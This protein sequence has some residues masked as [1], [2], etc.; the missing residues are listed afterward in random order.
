MTEQGAAKLAPKI[1]VRQ[2][3]R[4]SALRLV[5]SVV[6]DP[7]RAMRSVYD[8]YGPLVEFGF[9]I[10]FYKR[11]QRF[12]LAVGARYNERVL[13]DTAT[14]GAGGLM[15]PGPKGST[16]RRIRSGLVSI[17]G[18]QHQYYRRLFLPPVRRAAVDGM[19]GQIGEIVQRAT[20]DWRR[21]EVVDLWPLVREVA[22]KVA[23]SVLFG[24]KE[25]FDFAEALTVADLIHH[26]VRMASSPEVRGCPINLR[27]LPYWRML[28]HAEQ[29]DSA[30]TSWAKKRRGQSRSNDLLSLFVNSPDEYG[31]P[32]ADE[33][34][35]SQV[36]TLF[37]ASYETCQT[38]L[39]WTL[40]LLAQQPSACATLVDELSTLPTFDNLSAARLDQCTWLDAVIKESMRLL[41][42]V[43]LQ[44]RRALQ[45]TDL[46]DCGIKRWTRVILSPFLTNR[47]PELYSEGDHFKPERWSSIDPSQYEYLVFSAGPRT[48]IGNWFAMT[49]L[50]IAV[51]QIMRSYRLTVVPGARIDYRV[52]VAMWPNRGI[53]VVI[54]AQD[55]RFSAS[56][57]GGKI[58]RVVQF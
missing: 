40:F 41:P 20:S 52:A 26:H 46:V 2:I 39:A 54:H 5:P 48:C 24:A 12:I 17:D 37:G 36:L 34:I 14:F 18:W 13:R 43:P 15:Q 42:P 56:A 55:R 27:G 47:H 51:A 32:L 30:I 53:P 22:Q 25:N 44:V 6:R 8:R 58:C 4:R 7:I 19:I 3:S 11:K 29:V 28:H 31:N 9:R 35:A 10:P 16:H 57:I 21:G 38:A 23:V 45:D 49:F 50:K 33:Q 1:A